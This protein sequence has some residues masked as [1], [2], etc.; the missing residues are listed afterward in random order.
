M[1]TYRKRRGHLAVTILAVLAALAVAG[2]GSTKAGSDSTAATPATG[3][4]I[5]R[6]FA[7]AMVPHHQSAVAMA[8]IAQEQTSRAQIKTLAANIIRSQNAEI[9]TQTAIRPRVRG[10]IPG[11]RNV[12]LRVWSRR[13]NASCSAISCVTPSSS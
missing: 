11:T 5:D 3:N 13:S 1:T 6:A 9:T 10:V 8:K 12:F 2:C 7:T 4:S